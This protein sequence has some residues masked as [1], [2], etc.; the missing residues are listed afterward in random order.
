VAVPAGEV[1]EKP[2]VDL[3]GAGLPADEFESL[4]GQVSVKGMGRFN[5]FRRRGPAK[6]GRDRTHNESLSA[7][8]HI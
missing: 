4:A 5:R 6:G 3:E 2:R 1:A 7:I 8:F